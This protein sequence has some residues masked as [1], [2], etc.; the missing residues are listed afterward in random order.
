MR[1]IFTVENDQAR[2]QL[3]EHDSVYV[4]SM[5]DNQLVTFNVTHVGTTV[6]GG[7][8]IHKS[9]PHDDVFYPK[10]SDKKRVKIVEPP[11]ELISAV[12]QSEPEKELSIERIKEW[13]SRYE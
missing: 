2:E 11:I 6:G 3:A 9:D 8:H 12:E 4:W 10:V 1:V 5:D 13:H 7:I